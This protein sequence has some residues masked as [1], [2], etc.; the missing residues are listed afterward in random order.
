MERARSCRLAG[1]GGVHGKRRRHI[2]L[3]TVYR[4]RNLAATRVEARGITKVRCPR[5][6]N[7]IE[8]LLQSLSSLWLHAVN[9]SNE[10]LER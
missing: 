7:P 4:A 8:G 6:D 5:V 2:V 10:T 9:E 3:P 1:R